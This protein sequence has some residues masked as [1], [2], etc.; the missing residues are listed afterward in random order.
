MPHESFRVLVVDAAT[1]VGRSLVR[2]LA[3]TAYE[4]RALVSDPDDEHWAIHAG[5]D[6]VVVADLTATP[7]LS[8]AVADVDAICCSVADAG[9]KYLFGALD[10]GVGVQHLLDAARDRN[11]YVVLHSRIGVG[12]STSGMAF[13]FR[14]LTY[15][16]RHA[17]QTTERYL[18]ETGIPHTILRTGR[19]TD[20][21]AT[22][23]DDGRTEDAAT[24]GTQPGASAHSSP[25]E[26]SSGASDGSDGAINH[27]GND[28]FTIELEDLTDPD[29]ATDADSPPADRSDVDDTVFTDGDDEK[30]GDANARRVTADIVD[31]RH[32]HDV[33]T[34]SGGDTISGRISRTDL[35]WLMAAALTTPEARNRTFEVVDAAVAGPTTNGVDFHWRGPET[36]LV[37]R[38]SGYSI[39][40]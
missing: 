15:R 23:A 40:S 37:A 13:P 33:V 3:D 20:D 18:R 21:T 36:G 22:G 26:T 31:P 25:V 10:S 14:V 39:P 30:R 34:A 4:V 8:D 6:D 32:S 29:A 38:R 27:L 28:D 1:T 7:D 11:P 5:A 24:T 19:V 2:Y 35:A 17:L 12:D 9:R 16:I